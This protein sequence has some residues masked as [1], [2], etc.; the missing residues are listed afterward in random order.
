M[1]ICLILWYWMFASHVITIALLS[2][3]NQAS[4]WNHWRK[5]PGMSGSANHWRKNRGMSGSAWDFQRRINNI[6]ETINRPAKKRGLG[7]LHSITRHLLD[8]VLQPGVSLL[9]PRP[10]M[11][12][13]VPVLGQWYATCDGHL[14]PFP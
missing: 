2:Q 5:N 4:S 6:I 8:I 13:W 12:P 14:S 3:L 7:K 10:Q 11:I 9:Q 1:L